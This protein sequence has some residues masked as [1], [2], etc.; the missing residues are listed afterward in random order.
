[1]KMNDL[2]NKS[3]IELKEEI[4]KS[5]KKLFNIRF[6]KANGQIEGLSQLPFIRKDI[7]RIK[8]L[9]TQRKQQVK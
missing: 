2:K 9:L 4:L 1:M 8:T 5:R 3:E 6:Q 7:A